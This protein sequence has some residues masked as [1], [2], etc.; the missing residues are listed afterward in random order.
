LDLNR[1]GWRDALPIDMADDDARALIEGVVRHAERGAAGDI[2]VQRSLVQASDGLW[3]CTITLALDGEI[4]E[5]RLSDLSMRLAGKLRAKIKPVGDL[6]QFVTG[7]LAILE[8]YEDEDETRWWRARP[9]RPVANLL[10]PPALRVDL[11]IE[12][13]R[14]PL[15]NLILPDA[16]GLSPEPMAFAADPDNRFTLVARGSHATRLPELIIAVPH[17]CEPTLELHGSAQ[18]IGSVRHLKLG[19][20]RLEGELRLGW[21]GQIF[22]WRT[23]AE[24]ES[25]LGLE[26]D[27]AAESGVRGQAWRHPLRLFVREG[28]SRRQVK[29]GEVRWRP[30]RGGPWRSWPTDA[31]RGD[32]TFVLVRDSVTVSR[33]TASIAPE[34]FS[35]RAVSTPGRALAISGLRGATISVDGIARGRCTSDTTIVDRARAARNHL[36]LNAF[37]PDGTSWQTELHDLTARPGFT[38]GSGAELPIGWRGCIDALFGIYATCPDQGK[39]TLEVTPAQ[40]KRCITRPVRGE[41]PLYA[42]REDIRALLAATGGLDDSVRLEW[43]GAG[44]PRIQIG[45]FDVALEACEGEVWP[46]YADLMRVAASSAARMT[47]L[48]R[49]LADPADEHVLY[50]G[51]ADGCRMRRFAPPI[52]ALGGPWLIYGRVDDRFHIRPRVVFTHSLPSSH[53]TRLAQLVL[54]SDTVARRQDLKE[55]LQSG[56]VTGQELDEAR[57]LIVS[58]QTEAPL[59][60]LDVAIALIAAPETAVRLLSTCSEKELD[61]VLALEQ[62]MDFL[63]CVTPVKTW[64]NAF[65]TRQEALRKLMAALPAKDAARYAQE[66]V[67]A[68]FRAIVFRQP[69]LAF[70]AISAGGR[71]EHWFVDPAQTANDCVARNGH[72]DDG[73]FWPSDL[74]LANRL[75]A[76]LP[77]W[78]QNKQPYCW[79]VLAAPF[80]A[81]RVAAGFIPWKQTLTGALRW[82]RL[83]DPIYF[84]HTLPCALLPLA[85]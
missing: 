52:A 18:P 64:T 67:N 27:G 58:F 38:D 85:K 44:G 63:W 54:S 65:A 30:V 72:A 84:D 71:I 55:L 15:G 42:L 62:E 79:D 37:W 35:T 8:A 3:D 49:P 16:E 26:F 23:G 28:S 73:V 75:G 47:L 7:D 24:R 51:S 32:V 12:S 78:I 57:T 76:E 77:A 82:A 36:S 10:C 53:R 1:P 83:F 11:L 41:M 80:V 2:A 33:A 61:M 21:E 81:A 19:L 39:L 13:D 68:M 59:Q 46:S 70:H 56:A 29:N 20:Y 34:G 4:Q 14:V 66:A 5:S 6:L 60:S 45:L 9:L 22:R 50:E 40:A 69:A 31:P 74:H 17:E 48:A 25:F 43:V